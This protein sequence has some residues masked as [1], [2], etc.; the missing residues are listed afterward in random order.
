MIYAS[1]PLSYIR[2][3]DDQLFL[4]DLIS[5]YDSTKETE[6]VEAK[7]DADYFFAKD[8]SVLPEWYCKEK[9]DTGSDTLPETGMFRETAADIIDEV[10]EAIQQEHPDIKSK[11][12][13]LE[14]SPDAAILY[15]E[16]YYNLESSIE[17]QLREKFVLKMLGHIPADA[18]WRG[19]FCIISHHGEPKAILEIE[20]AHFLN[21]QSL[22]DEYLQTTDHYFGDSDFI[23]YLQSRNIKVRSHPFDELTT[24]RR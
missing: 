15:G 24:G 23:R 2:E 17:D 11:K 4:L 3:I 9:E 5:F 6:A 20:N 10:I 18:E 16:S 14:E 12:E 1:G 22:L 19:D 8:G 7:H 13:F 21:I